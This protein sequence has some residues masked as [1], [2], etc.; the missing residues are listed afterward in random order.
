MLYVLIAILLFG[1]LIFVHELGHFLTARLFGVTVIEFAIGMGPKIISKVSKKS[2]TRYSL[3]LFPI[4][5]FC[6]M[7]GED[8]ES[9][10]DGSF[11]SK[12]VWQ[13][14]I[15]TAA[16]SLSNILIG[17]IVMTIITACST[18]VSTTIGSF[19]EGAVSNSVLEIGDEIEGRIVL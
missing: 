6:S 15:I 11:S 10:N 4:G 7:D 19:D 8:K 2:G 18:R 5:G 16:G 13:R 1:I 12:P 3:R 14:I 17:I 9:E